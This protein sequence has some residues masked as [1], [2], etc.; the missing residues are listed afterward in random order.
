MLSEEKI[1]IMTNLAIFEKKE[2]KNISPAYRYFRSDYI[3]SKM[4][5]SFFSYTLSFLLILA[6]CALYYIDRWLNAMELD[7]LL[8][9]GLTIG[10]VYAA[11]LVVYLIIS[12]RVYSKKYEY[13]SRG[14]KVY[15]SK[16]KRLDK[17]YETGSRPA[18]RIKGGRSQ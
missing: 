2:G 3:S 7:S 6:L 16:L 12:Y 1:K 5:R 14:T 17:R 8:N 18:G 15:L 13:A 9:T 11:G 4:F 10:G